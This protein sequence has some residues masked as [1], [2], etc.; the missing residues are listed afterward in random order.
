MII[1]MPR[2]I[3]QDSQH[4]AKRLSYDWSQIVSLVDQ[5]L[6]VFHAHGGE[7]WSKAYSERD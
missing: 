6:R 7:S 5:M 2:I 3:L 4:E 1:A